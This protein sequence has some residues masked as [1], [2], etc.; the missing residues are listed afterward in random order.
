MLLVSPGQCHVPDDIAHGRR[1]FGLASHLYSLRHHASEG[2]GDFQ[3]L[4]RL[5]HLTGEIGG[6]YAG[7][8]PLHH[9][10]PSDRSRASPYQPSD[11]HYID[12]I[13]ISLGKLLTDMPLAGT[14]RLAEQD[15]AAFASLDRLPLIDYAAVWEAKARILGSAFA[16][17]PGSPAFEE[18]RREGGEALEAHGR[19]E[20]ARLGERVTPA[21]IAYRAFLQ[22]IAEHAA[23]GSGSPWQ[24][25]P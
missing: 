14:A 4:E 24:P 5:A 12:P 19:F 11:R 7:L 22:W 25:L 2:I 1:V 18:F 15:L 17:F 10:F 6:R 21:R 23:P 13:Y 20:A 8:N 9:L 16:E 3:T